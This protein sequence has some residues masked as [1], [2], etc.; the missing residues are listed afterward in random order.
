MKVKKHKKD[1][2]IIVGDSLEEIEIGKNLGIKTVAITNGYVS[3]ARLKAAKPDFLIN[4]L[5]ELI[6]IVENSKN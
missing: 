4:T 2:I 5:T 3:T 1:D 6:D